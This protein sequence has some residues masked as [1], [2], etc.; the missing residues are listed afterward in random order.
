MSKWM[1]TMVGSN[2]DTPAADKNC[3]RGLLPIIL[4]SSIR[5]RNLKSILQ[6]FLK[7][8]FFACVQIFYCFILHRFINHIVGTVEIIFYIIFLHSRTPPS[9]IHY[10]MVPLMTPLKKIHN[11]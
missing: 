9:Y 11:R 5:Q 7:P 2:T 6:H 8:Y 4:K 3:R 10:L 1:K